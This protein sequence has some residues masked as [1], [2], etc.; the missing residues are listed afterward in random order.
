MKDGV[1][2]PG[3]LYYFDGVPAW[4]I[5]VPQPSRFA[6]VRMTL[7]FRSFRLPGGALLACIYR[8]FDIPDQ[9]FYVH[10]VFDPSEP[11][12]GRYLEASRER[13][14]WFVELKGGGQD[15]D[16][17]RIV[18]L[19]GT[20]FEESH[21]LALARNGELGGRLRGA[22]TL[23]VFLETFEPAAKSGGWEVG[24]DA[25]ATQFNA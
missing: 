8:L 25:V 10:R 3:Y 20:G 24:W 4:T 16:V 11:E 2:R 1:T 7:E 19:A 5:R 21:R 14:H 18:S 15:K 23:S 9:P 13:N 12:V 6:A 22:K 17:C